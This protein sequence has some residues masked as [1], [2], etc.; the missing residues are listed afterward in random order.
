M[1]SKCSSTV[2]RLVHIIIVEV[3]LKTS[4]TS[5]SNLVPSLESLCTHPHKHVPQHAWASSHLLHAC[6]CN[7]HRVNH[8]EGKWR[9]GCRVS[10]LAFIHK[11]HRGKSHLS[12]C[13]PRS[14]HLAVS[15]SPT[16]ATLWHH[17]SHQPYSHDTG[18]Y[19]DMRLLYGQSVC[20]FSVLF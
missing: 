19:H 2:F 16:K 8:A 9:W 20:T 3:Y 15:F 10:K 1:I 14:S 4:K 18:Q 6:Y 13:S 5:R 12:P 11:T 17:K 7:A